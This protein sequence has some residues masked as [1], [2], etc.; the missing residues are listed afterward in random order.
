MKF[1]YIIFFTCVFCILN[2][3]A[4]QK[5]N[6]GTEFW[7]GYGYNYKFL[8]EFPL[9]NQEL[10]LYIS[11]TQAATV[12]VSVNGTAWSQTM[13]IPAN[14]VDASILVPKT[15][16][17]DAR[18]LTDGL[19]DRGIHIVSNVPVAVYAHCYGTMVSGATMLMPV[20]TYGYAYR[21]INFTQTSSASS[22]PVQSNITQN[23]PDWY[24]WFYVVASEDNTKVEITPSDTTKNGWL[25]NQTYTVTLNKGQTYNVFGKLLNGSNA[26]WAASK[27]MTGSKV[28]SV[29]GTDG[30][31][32]PI[33]MFSGSS[34]L[35]ICKGDGGEFVHQQVFP[36]Q[37][38]G[39]RYLTYH[40]INNGNSDIL[41]TNR[42]YYRIC[43]NDPTTIVKR[44]GIIMTGLE[45]NFFYS[46]IDSTGGN[47][48][49]ANK[50]ILVAQYTVNKNECWRNINSNVVGALSYGDPEMFYLSPLEQGQKNIRFFTSRKST[51]DYVYVNIVLPTAAV[52]SLKIDGNS[53][54]ASQIIPH[55]NYPSYSVAVARIIGPADHHQLDCDSAVTATVYGLGN[56]ESYGYN[57]GCNIKNLNN[58][59]NINNVF[60]ASNAIN[61]L[62]PIDS[63]TCPNTP[64]K[65]TIK[66]AFPANSI[67]WKLSQVPGLQPNVDSVIANPNLLGTEN[68]NGRTYYRYSLQQNFTLPITG[69]HKL[70]ISYTTPEIT[71]CNQTETDTLFITVN[72]GPKSDFSFSPMISTMAACLNDS[73]NFTGTLLNGNGF[74]VSQYLWTFPDGTTA[75]TPN[76]KKKFATPGTKL[77]RFASIATNGCFGDTVKTVTIFDSPKA[78]FGISNINICAKDSI[79]ITDSSSITIGTINNYQYNMGNGTIINRNNN[80][81]FYY[82]FNTAGIYTISLI[83]TSNNACKS[84][85]AYRT[86]TVR[87]LPYANFGFDRSICVNDSVRFT[88]TSTFA[89]GIITAYHWNFGNGNTLIRNTNTPF[90]HQY[91]NTGNYIV[92]MVAVGNNGCTSDTAKRTVMVGNKPMATVTA[93]WT[94]C[95]DSL[96]VAK[97]SYG[98]PGA[99]YYWDFG[100]GTQRSTITDTVQVRYPVAG[101]YIIRHSVAVSLGCNS[102]T[103][104]TLPILI[105]SNPIAQFTTDKLA[106]CQGE[107]ININSALNTANVNTWIWQLPNGQVNNSVPPFS[108]PTFSFGTNIVSLV[109]EKNGCKSKPFD[110]SLNVN[111]KPNINAGPDHNITLNSTAQLNA[112]VNGMGTFNYIW[113]PSIGLNNP[114]V[115]TPIAAPQITTT[116]TITVTNTASN[117]VGTDTVVV[118]VFSKLLVPNAFSPNDDGKNDVWK[119]EA[120]SAYPKAVV[121]VYNRW[122][123]KILD[124]SN[125]N[126]NPWDGRIGGKPVSTGTYVYYIKL[127]NLENE[128]FKGTLLILR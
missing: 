62:N 9:N 33:G 127:N 41:E 75:T 121:T 87:P 23:G 64:F 78:N 104:R 22:L 31:C 18:I 103:S 56:W 76:T 7:L 95:V 94:P 113:T 102:D 3:Q 118:G 84:D 88:D 16:A 2:V 49:E 28:V 13:N 47:Y 40:T 53:L 19:S 68:I 67:T 74:T 70:P 101:N 17:A 45:N 125:Y 83:T 42:N 59:V 97:S 24:S 86:I 54:P 115:L 114:T 50:P 111:T 92:T 112:T 10:A 73:L 15:G 6:R 20:E 34:G 117:C 72:D 1:W 90:Y 63:F 109:T 79:Q 89:S 66:L 116:Y 55:P 36:N 4:Q 32:H 108:T 35:R 39:T 48:Y 80:A 106:Y 82:R 5:S 38:W 14:T 100:N 25:P 26:L 43:V 21:S 128:T 12:T 52:G 37:A 124:R 119:M 96:V 123:Q 99:T 60:S 77:V 126:L 30:K 110:I 81:P 122:G 71:N 107:N 93:Q 27:D 46:D 57:A 58:F 69:I 120:L 11:C 91:I 8:N 61:N 105:Y 51:I 65:L 44:N 85:T 29:V 98:V